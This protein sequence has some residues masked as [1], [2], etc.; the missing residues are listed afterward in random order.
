MQ[1]PPSR[2]I[3]SLLSSLR[4]LIVEDNSFTRKVNRGLLTH[5]GVKTIY[6]AV[7]GVAGLD[8]ISKYAP[9]LV[10]VDW[11]LPL[12]TGSE[13]VRMVRSP[14]TFAL[15]DIPIIVLTC[16]GERWRVIEAQRCGA[17]EF[18]VKPASAQAVLDRIVSIFMNPRPMVQLPNYYGPQPRGAFVQFLRHC[19]NRQDAAP[20]VVPVPPAEAATAPPA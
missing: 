15:H 7:D 19:A 13:L 3:S 10:I 9:D 5:L 11:D 6:E 14:Q 4:V 18:L 12:L 8:A 1:A 16:H 17:H 20:R 2:D